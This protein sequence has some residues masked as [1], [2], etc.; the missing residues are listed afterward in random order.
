MST[1]MIRSCVRRLLRSSELAETV[2]GPRLIVVAK[3]VRGEAVEK[4]T[5]KIEVA[6]P[7]VDE[8]DAVIESQAERNSPGR[9]RD[10]SQGRGNKQGVL[11]PYFLKSGSG[12]KGSGCDMVHA[13]V[14]TEDQQNT[15]SQGAAST[16][17]A[18]AAT[19]SQAAQAAAQPP[20]LGL[21]S[22][23]SPFGI[24]AEEVLP[25]KMAQVT[26]LAAGV[27]STPAP[28]A[29]KRALE[30]HSPGRNTE[31]LKVL[32][33]PE[34]RHYRVGTMLKNHNSKLT[35]Q[36]PAKGILLSK[37]VP[38]PSTSD[39]EVTSLDELPTEWWSVVDNA[40]GGHQY[41][42]LT[43]I[44]GARVE[45][46]LD[47][48]AGSN[49]VTEELVCGVLN[50]AKEMGL[51]PDDP[52]FP[53]VQMERWVHAEAVHGIAASSPV[54]LK[55]AVVMRVTLLEGFTPEDCKPS[56]EILV[57]A[58][59]SAKGRSDWHG[60]ILGGHS[61]DCQSR[62]ELGFRPGPTAHML[63]TLGIGM[64]RVEHIVQRPDRACV[65]RSVISSLDPWIAGEEA[66]ELGP[67]D[68]ALVPVKRVSLTAGLGKDLVAGSSVA[69]RR[70]S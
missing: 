46:M 51:K 54:P 56:H 23:S 35:V 25:E 69:S 63:D 65:A 47:G 15:Q 16:S 61:L 4:G 43:E 11:C 36:V 55:G 68:G 6:V 29:E 28:G 8:L 3:A 10:R 67:D 49:H 48:C 7:V 37:P 45:T 18:P 52:K 13:L 41:K 40:S 12:K 9:G 21:A 33:K 2:L 62:G 19:T 60:L 27:V 42:T 5:A 39:G 1:P 38:P 50:K 20:L 70:Q 66:K 59:I 53:V 22:L 57:R 58:K 34:V 24:L 30:A 14:V 32:D 64:P 31:V 44:Y 26:V 17:S